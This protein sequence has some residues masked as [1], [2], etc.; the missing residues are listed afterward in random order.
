[1]EKSWTVRGFQKF[2]EASLEATSTCKKQ[3]LEQPLSTII[4]NGH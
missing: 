3:S 4:I 1:M 2:P